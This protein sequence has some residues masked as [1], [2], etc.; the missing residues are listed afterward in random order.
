MDIPPHKSD[1]RLR[2]ARVDLVSPPGATK[3]KN[4]ETKCSYYQDVM[5]V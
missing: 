2:M 3:Q 4:G 1:T 5:A